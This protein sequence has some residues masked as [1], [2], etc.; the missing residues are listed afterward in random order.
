MGSADS[1]DS[2]RDGTLP[3]AVPVL[4]RTPVGIL[5]VTG[6]GEDFRLRFSSSR[7]KAPISSGISGASPERTSRSERNRGITREG[8]DLPAWPPLLSALERAMSGAEPVVKP[9]KRA[10]SGAEPVVKPLERADSSVEAVVR[11]LE[12]ADSPIWPVPRRFGRPRRDRSRRDDRAA[13]SGGRRGRAR[14][15][16]A[17]RR[18]G[19]AGRGTDEGAAR[20][21]MI[22][23]GSCPWSAE[24]AGAP[25]TRRHPLT[26]N[27]LTA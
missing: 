4:S 16:P 18:S 21:Q 8:L 23:A 25:E 22:A 10:M 7:G 14:Q 15:R 20:R 17:P 12:P 19:G 24:V 11:R 3:P 9:L 1:P 5:V 27:D 26:L 2:R 13:G 6:E